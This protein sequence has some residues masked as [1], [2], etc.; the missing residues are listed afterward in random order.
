LADAG[1]KAA[2]STKINE[3]ALD[4]HTSLFERDPYPL[5]IKNDRQLES[6]STRRHLRSTV[7]A[8]AAAVSIFMCC[9]FFVVQA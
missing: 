7:T 6:S 5:I 8:T 9:S 2:A 4:I 3:K 1:S